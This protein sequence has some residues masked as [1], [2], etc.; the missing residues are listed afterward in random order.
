MIIFSLIVHQFTINKIIFSSFLHQFTMNKIIFSSFLHQ[1]QNF[2]IIRSVE[3]N[4]VDGFSPNRAWGKKGPMG[5]LAP[6][7]AYY[8][9]SAWPTKEDFQ[10]KQLPGSYYL[11]PWKQLVVG[12]YAHSADR[13]IRVL[14]FEPDGIYEE[15][16]FKDRE[17]QEE[18]DLGDLMGEGSPSCLSP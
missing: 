18:A 9:N 6:L 13:P 8:R 16:R 15:Q 12:S 2:G 4:S 7:G 1:F 11:E 5:T 3:R 14:H 17:A 10:T